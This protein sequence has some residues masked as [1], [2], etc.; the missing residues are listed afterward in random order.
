MRC[1]DLSR[2]ESPVYVSYAFGLVDTWYSVPILGLTSCL[3]ST[4]LFLVL[5]L[6]V[7]AVPVLFCLVRT[8]DPGVPP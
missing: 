2:I 8:P 5:V 4:C 7:L 3:L 1:R 6:P